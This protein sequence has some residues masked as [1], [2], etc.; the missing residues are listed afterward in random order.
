MTPPAMLGSALALCASLGAFKAPHVD[1]LPPPHA[2][3]LTPDDT[4]LGRAVLTNISKVPKTVEVNLTAGVARM[5]FQPGT[6]TEVFAYNG[7]VPGPTLDVR[8]GDRVIVHFRNDLPEPTTVHWHGIH[9]PFE[10][11]GSPFRPIMPGEK[12]DYTFTVRSGTA[13]TY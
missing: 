12:H 1:R 5:S 13:G 2:S 4:A 6:T 9:L 10:S 8:E 7:R 3:T 11:D